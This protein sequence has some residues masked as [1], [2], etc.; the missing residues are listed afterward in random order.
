MATCERLGIYRLTMENGTKTSK[1]EKK[2]KIKS[3]AFQLRQS[4]PQHSTH[5]PTRI[6][7]WA[8]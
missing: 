1:I 3:D 7:Y 5:R 8:C 2:E 6:D 4:I